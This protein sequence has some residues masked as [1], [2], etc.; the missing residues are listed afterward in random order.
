M[1]IFAEK[2]ATLADTVRLVADGPIEAVAAALR[3]GAGRPAIAIGSGGSAIMAEYFASCRSSLGLGLTL[4]QTPLEFV[5]AP[6]SCNGFS[7]WLFS[8]GA[9]N[10]DVEG[11]LKAA[12]ASDAANV[13]LVTVNEWGSTAVA[14]ANNSRA[15]LIVVPVAE[16]K[17]GF[18]ATHSLV[19]MVACVLA[20]SDLVANPSEGSR[21]AHSLAESVGRAVAD[22][23]STVPSFRQGDTLCLLCDPQCRT[24][25]RLIETSL[26]E[27]GIAPVQVADFRNFAHGRHVWA[28][29]HPHSMF[30]L[31]VTTALTRDLWENI[32]RALPSTI[33]I[34]ELDLGYAGRFRT[35]LSVIEGLIVVHF[36]GV[37][38]EID[39]AKPGRGDFAEAIYG[40]RGLADVV[41][42]LSPAV[43]H[44]LEAIRRHDDQ[45]CLP[46]PPDAICA[47][48]LADLEKARLGGIVLDYD[49]TVVATETRLELPASSLVDELIRLAD[50]GI[51]IA[52]ATGRGGSAGD[53]LR[54]SLPVR[55]HSSIT[56]GYYNGGHIRSLDVDIDDDPPFADSS[57]ARVADWIECRALLKPKCLLKRGN[58]QISVKHHDV[59]ELHRFKHE[60]AMCPDIANG[61][62]RV[63]TSHHSFDLLPHGTS[64]TAVLQ[65]IRR[66]MSDG[67]QVLS[68]GDSGEPGGND[69]ELLANRPSISVD[70]VC[71]DV[72]GSWSLFGRASSGPAALL[73]ILRALCIE[74]GRG[75]MDFDKLAASHG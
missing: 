43:Q 74:N 15:E 45:S 35:A 3:E 41:G 37:A 69:V 56:M 11:A 47:D 52:F 26:W 61:K 60:L 33:R 8:A 38:T 36:L 71:G 10:P 54:Q 63:L 73:R 21:S 48:R 51:A 7:I 62:I 66:T 1:T 22:L 12:V 64:K 20:A 53:A 9:D 46:C 16:R 39:P 50:G 14:A 5:L 75:R 13:R 6:E 68:I 25:A 30:V 34:S 17:D 2:L 4:V 65:E 31:A 55:L 59:V 32:K 67:L 28:A 72:Q 27:T 49:G 44:K 42:R 57:L 29:R 40:D 23:R 58:V 19:G 18:L 24:F 70:G